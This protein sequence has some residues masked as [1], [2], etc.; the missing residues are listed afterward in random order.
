[1]YEF[2][3]IPKCVINTTEFS[4]IYSGNASIYSVYIY[5][6]IPYIDAQFTST[7]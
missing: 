1:M 2:Y 4:A 3:K 6:E 7:E 5:D